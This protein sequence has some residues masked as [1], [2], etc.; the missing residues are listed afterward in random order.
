MAVEGHNSLGYIFL[1]SEETPETGMYTPLIIP[2]TL[3][4]ANYVP[5]RLERQN[6][7]ENA[8]GQAEFEV[9]L[10]LESPGA[11]DAFAE[12]NRDYYYTGEDIGF[13]PQL[14][15]DVE[16]DFSDLRFEQAFLDGQISKEQVAPPFSTIRNAYFKAF[17]NG[18]TNFLRKKIIDVVSDYQWTASPR[19]AKLGTANAIDSNINDEVPYVR[20][21]EKYFLFNNLIAQAL[22]SISAANQSS[23]FLTGNTTATDAQ[24]ILNN[25][26][27]LVESNGIFQSA[28]ARVSNLLDQ[29]GNQIQGI[30]RRV[31]LFGPGDIFDVSE[32]TRS[33]I[34]ESISGAFDGDA[35]EAQAFVQQ[36]I[37]EA[38]A[39]VR[40]GADAARN[41]AGRLNELITSGI[42]TVSPIGS[43]IVSG[44]KNLIGENL[45]IAQALFQNPDLEPVLI[46]Y[47]GLYLVGST[48]FEYKIPYLENNI[49]NN[50]NSF[51]G[52]NVS[53]G[54]LP[55]LVENVTG[56]AETVTSFMTSFAQAGTTSIER[57]KYYDFAREGQ[58]FKVR[59]P[60]YNTHPAN[61]SNVVSNYRLVFLLLYQNMPMRT[62]K[63]IVEPPCVYDVTI[64]GGR[65]E[66]FCY[67]SSINVKHNGNTRVM[68]IPTTGLGIQ[69]QGKLPENIEAII[70]DS[71]LIEME[72]TPLIPHTKNLMAASIS[73]DNL[74]K[75]KGTAS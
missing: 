41:F 39:T 56:L 72:F 19:S 51:G 45:K 9:G 61:F 52:G 64:P 34:V 67:M 30:T 33:A 28:A 66:P 47:Q 48:G 59:L 11:F 32:Q 43:S 27:A 37:D 21:K 20:L 8:L 54:F 5:S 36:K 3:G 13:G 4:A 18:K 7:I 23:S 2:N 25:L 1:N 24:N 10:N 35:S 71:Y 65:R 62:N 12:S 53:L 69:G 46:P 14:T 57:T 70:P 22:Y 31:N 29:G 42:N 58:P 40:N 68:N 15:G 74:E 38:N 6:L 75:V 73:Y 49:L 55:E 60:L 16:G 17:K 50:S 44:A 63:V 26:M